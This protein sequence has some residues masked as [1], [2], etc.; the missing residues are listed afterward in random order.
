M[1]IFAPKSDVQSLPKPSF[2]LK[3]ADHG[4]DHEKVLLVEGA[5]M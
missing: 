2:S 3:P 5:A 4:L 1:T